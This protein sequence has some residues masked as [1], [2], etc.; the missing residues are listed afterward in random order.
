M[1]DKFV[2]SYYPA[3]KSTEIQ[4]VITH[5]CQEP[6]ES[7]RDVYEWYSGFFWQCPH[8]GFSDAFTVGNFYNALTLESQRVIESLCLGGDILTKTPPELNKMISTLGARDHYWGQT[9]RGRSSS[10]RGVHSMEARSG[11][12]QEVAE[13]VHTLNQPN[14]LILHR[15]LAG[16]LVAQWQWCESSSHLVEDC[17][18]MRESTTSQEQLDFI[19]NAQR[20]DP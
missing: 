7:L 18:A 4:R 8:H 19:A 16:H 6:D 20:L 12:E 5:F 17:L 9:T 3:S 1:A 2:H 14:S 10:D 15:G 13:L 11:L